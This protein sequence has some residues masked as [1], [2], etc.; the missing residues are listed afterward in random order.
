[1]RSRTS[2]LFALFVALATPALA[3]W[4]PQLTGTPIANPPTT[5][6]G[7]AAI[8]DG[9]GGAFVFWVDYRS[10]T[11]DVYG[12]H[13]L[14]D[15][16][17]AW[18][19]SGVPVCT[20]AG[21]QDRIA[22]IADGSGGAIVG[23]RDQRTFATTGIDVYVQRVNAAGT[24]LWTANGVPVCTATGQQN[25][26][27]LVTDGAGGVIAVWEDARGASQ[28]IYARRVTGAGA[29]QW[30][31]N[32]SPVCTDP[33]TQQNMVAVTDG[34]GGVIVGWQDARNNAATQL[35]LYA[36]RL[37]GSGAGQW[38]ANGVVITI[39]VQ[40]QEH[41]VMAADG[42]GGAWCAFRDAVA[43]SD[44]NILVGRLTP[45]GLR[46]YGT[47]GITVCADAADQAY[48]QLLPDADGGAFV[49]WQDFRNTTTDGDLYMQRVT[50]DGGVTW[51]ANG[52]SSLVAPGAQAPLRVTSDGAG[53]FLVVCSDTRT[54]AQ[55][56]GLSAQRITPAGQVQFGSQGLYVSNGVSTTTVAAVPETN[57]G[58]LVFIEEFMPSSDY[59][60]GAHRVDHFGYL[61]DPAPRLTSVR[62]VRGDQGGQVVARW[63][64][65]YLDDDPYFAVT[66]YRVFRSVPGALARAWLASGHAVADDGT[67]APAGRVVVSLDDDATADFAWEL[68]TEVSASAG[69]NEYSAVVPTTG[70]SSASF[71][72]WTRVRVQARNGNGTRFW[73][74]APDSAVSVD[75]LAPAVPTPFTGVYQGGSTL[76][77]WGA[78][79]ELDL[80]GYRLHRGPSVSFVPSP[81]NLVATPADPGFVDPAG[82]A[83]VYKLCAVDV[84]G[85]A[86]GFATVVPAGTVSSPERAPLVLA[87]TLA[88]P[89]PVRGGATL[90]A[91]LPAAARVELA[92]YDAAGRRVRALLDDD[93]AAGEFTVHWDGRDDRGAALAPG[94]YLARLVA[95]GDAR[96][97]RLCVLR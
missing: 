5:Q 84:H 93:R 57:G 11:G 10:G 17:L 3:A 56:L 51:A 18:A 14:A 66:A 42:N 38:T 20:A 81:A 35:D 16:A 78:N 61:G 92:I 46:L 72:P 63:T 97:A 70:D 95:N 75:D 76:L 31:A 15:G 24:A 19:A 79:T 62:D 6:G 77:S 34:A 7:P 60:V 74:S 32:G 73:Y 37:S 23:W 9:A 43:F 71:L 91:A 29:A 21:T 47:N 54:Q 41:L 55:L 68:V 52:A 53:G 25:G 89:Q 40:N 83:Y 59:M 39:K 12:Q 64:R 30:T 69:T 22:V 8:P 49:A 67:A 80:A 44:G 86:S 28:D 2:I 94:V 36:Q 4:S 50:V 1:M 48:P 85:N 27:A 13:V 58:A 26:P 87:L 65:S 96:H 82:A 45:Q 88:S 33:T 90:R